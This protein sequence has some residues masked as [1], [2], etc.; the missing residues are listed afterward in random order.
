ML[1]IGVGIGMLIGFFVF[2]NQVKYIPAPIDHY[3]KPAVVL[4]I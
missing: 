2:R 3:I 1:L 4:T